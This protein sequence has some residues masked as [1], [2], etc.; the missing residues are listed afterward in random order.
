M[1]TK[2]P[3]DRRQ[4]RGGRD[5]DYHQARQTRRHAG[6]LSPGGRVSRAQRCAAWDRLLASLEYG[7]AIGIS[8][9]DARAWK[10]NRDELYERD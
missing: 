2:I 7:I 3:G 10:F 4:G 1:R 5:G 6:T 9:A 8:D